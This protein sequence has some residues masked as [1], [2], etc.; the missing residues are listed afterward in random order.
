MPAEMMELPTEVL[1]SSRIKTVEVNLP[2]KAAAGSNRRPLTN[3]SSARELSS[4]SPQFQSRRVDAL[5]GE[6]VDEDQSVPEM[7]Q[8][9]AERVN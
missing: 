9:S 3:N 5:V 4:P 6:G 2:P 7:T 8:L 1:K